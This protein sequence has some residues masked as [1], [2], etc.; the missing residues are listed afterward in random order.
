MPRTQRK[1][2]EEEYYELDLE[3]EEIQTIQPNQGT[4]KIEGE[5]PEEKIEQFYYGISVPVKKH[6]GNSTENESHHAIIISRYSAAGKHEIILTDKME[7]TKREFKLACI[8]LESKNKKWNYNQVKNAELINSLALYHEI[9]ETIEYYFDMSNT[10]Y[11][12][13]LALWVM[14]TYVHML[15]ECYPYLFLHGNKESGKTKVL[16]FLS[17]TCFNAI[18]SG[19][20]TP[21]SIFRLVQTAQSTLLIDETEMLNR[22][23][24]D[25][26]QIIRALLLNGYKKGA[27]VYRVNNE[28][29]TMKVEEFGIYCPKAI[30]NITGIE[31]VLESRCI[32][33]IM[34]KTLNHEIGE[35][36]IQDDNP[37]WMK[38]RDQLYAWGLQEW[39][40]V[41]EMYSIIENPSQKI[42][43]RNWEIWKPLYAIA[44]L[45]DEAVAIEI[46]EI[47]E[48]RTESKIIDE[49][50]SEH[51]LEYKILDELSR[52]QIK[53]EE[54]VYL[55][56]ITK[57]IR[58][59]YIEP[60]EW[61]KPRSVGTYMKRMGF[62]TKKKDETGIYYLFFQDEILDAC[63]RLNYM[64]GSNEKEETTPADYF[65][66]KSP[67]YLSD[68]RT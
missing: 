37:H 25:S 53:P 57:G 66:Q 32:T 43:N 40:D 24:D 21:S 10:K 48:E 45:Y 68:D 3:R 65:E 4:I 64:P 6:S 16:R 59:S 63:S 30:A 35:R 42:G 58:G 2:T 18:H 44:K 36:E 17:Q 34:Q 38:L 22:K 55:K 54:K 50:I 8:P 56:E 20:I 13:L 67:L 29:E 61:I 19:N 9:K 41:K 33:I 49:Q 51:G 14:G 60:P 52:M 46:V 47:M 23:N 7:M 11:Y 1:P 39:A 5:I 28:S 26:A 31:D 15:F 27:P 12:G 62:Q